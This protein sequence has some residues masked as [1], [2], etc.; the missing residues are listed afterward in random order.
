[1][2]FRNMISTSASSSLSFRNVLLASAVLRVCLIFYSEWHD[3]RS[4]V[5]YTDVDY[6]VFTDAAQF[7]A[8]PGPGDENHARGPLKKLLGVT[9]K[10]GE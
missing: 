6:R 10:I 8:Y 2:K 7:L 9:L 4:L 1:M 3:A 5:K